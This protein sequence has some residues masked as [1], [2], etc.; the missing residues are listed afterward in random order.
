M[1]ITV[2][3]VILFCSFLATGQQLDSAKYIRRYNA[4]Y[5]ELSVNYG[6]EYFNAND[7]QDFA[8]N[9][10]IADLG[11]V[12]PFAEFKVTANE[13]Y[14]EGVILRYRYYLPVSYNINGD[15]LSFQGWSYGQ[16]LYKYLNISPMYKNLKMFAGIT[17]DIGRM[18]IKGDDIN[19]RNPFFTLNAFLNPSI[20]IKKRI[21]LSITAEYSFDL[22]KPIWK[23]LE[24]G[25]NQNIEFKKSGFSI[26]GGIGWIINYEGYYTRIY[27]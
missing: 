16:V 3:G 19:Y 22:S 27:K 17:T 25:N 24:D 10:N 9:Q 11:Q 4:E 26:R 1:K 7:L 13:N 18:T 20:I 21:S 2:I 15:N 14:L 5:V 23:G 12:S 8:N 6:Q